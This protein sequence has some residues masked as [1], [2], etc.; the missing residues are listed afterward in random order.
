MAL[1]SVISKRLASIFKKAN[2]SV[3]KN[4]VD[5]RVLTKFKEARRTQ[6]VNNAIKK[7]K[8][9]KI[10]NEKIARNILTKGSKEYKRAFRTMDSAARIDAKKTAERKEAFSDLL[11]A[12]AE[13][14]KPLS[15]IEKKAY[16]LTRGLYRGDFCSFESYSG[17]TYE[18][19]FKRITT[20]KVRTSSGVKE[21]L[22]IEIT[23]MGQNK[24]V[25][26]AVDLLEKKSN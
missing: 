6:K 7:E 19:M 13:V 16:K 2:N 9:N 12:R 25:K 17:R 24:S 21:I 20:A 3:P 10:I 18:G 22:A 5:P 4:S 8:V 14:K 23:P 1:P 26:L 11:R 15:S